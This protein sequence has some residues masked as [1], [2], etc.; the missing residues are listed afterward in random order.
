MGCNGS[1]ASP[2]PPHLRGRPAQVPEGLPEFSLPVRDAAD[3]QLA[4]ELLPGALLIALVV[5]LSSWAGA[6]KFALKDGYKIGSQ[7]EMLALGLANVAGAFQG[8]VPTQI[9]LSRMGI[10]YGM[11]VKSQLG[12]NVLVAAVVALG[13]L[14]LSPAF[15]AVPRPVL[16]AIIVSGAAHLTE[17]EQARYLWRVVQADSV[18]YRTDV[19]VWWV[20][21]VSTL[22]LGAFE[23]I[24][25]AV[26]V[27][28]VL[29]VYQ[30][31]SQRSPALVSAPFGGGVAK[32]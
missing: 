2:G 5:F 19:G 22:C 12:A 26:G 6:K 9:G 17:F 32:L 11:G 27:S 24:L 29:I 18:R 7:N 21:L 20:G 15:A 4:R 1:F 8:A 25:V 23:G 31:P 14:C 16:N 10:A 30:V 3:L 13:V 28:L